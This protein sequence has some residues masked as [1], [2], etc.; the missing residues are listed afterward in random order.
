MPWASD[1]TAR[2]LTGSSPH[3][4]PTLVHMDESDHLKYRRVTQSWFTQQKARS[5]ENR[6]RAIA[7]ASIDRMAERGSTR[8]FVRDVAIHYP[9]HVL[10]QILGVPEENEPECHILRTR[11]AMAALFGPR[12]V[13]ISRHQTSAQIDVSGAS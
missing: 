9:L 11:S 13:P 10:M 5:L 3:P 2:T 4:I 7:R 1:E 6:I 12:M 8:D